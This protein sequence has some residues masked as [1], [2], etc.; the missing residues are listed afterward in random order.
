MKSKWCLSIVCFLAGLAVGIVVAWTSGAPRTMAA[1]PTV[2]SGEPELWVVP[3]SPSLPPVNATAAPKPNPPYRERLNVIAEV[4]SLLQM[5]IVVPL[6]NGYEVNEGFIKVYGLTSGE[7][8]QLKASFSAAKKNI[9]M[10]EAKHASIEPYGENGYLISIPP[11]PQEGG[12]VYDGLLQS[13]H[14]VLGDERFLAYRAST[15]DM[16]TSGFG[17]FGLSE[18]IINVSPTKEGVNLTS[19]ASSSFDGNGPRKAHVDM[20]PVFFLTDYPEIYQRMVAAGFW[21]ETRK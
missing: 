17:M 21:K 1:R 14:E 16:E 10:L 13:I 20:N 12:A 6:L 9:A 3:S 19:Q 8:A 2:A 18:T 15:S 4:N 5:K 7:V 11:F